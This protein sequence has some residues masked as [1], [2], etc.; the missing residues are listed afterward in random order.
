MSYFAYK[1]VYSTKIHYSFP[2]FTERLWLSCSTNRHDLE[3]KEG[4][5]TKPSIKHTGILCFDT[6]ENA[7]NFKSSLPK[8]TTR[9]FDAMVLNKLALPAMRFVNPDI[10]SEE[11]LEKLWKEKRLLQSIRIE[12]YA[13]WP[14]GTEAYESIMLL[15]ECKVSIWNNCEKYRESSYVQRL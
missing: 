6:L 4:L 1:V 14:E 15:Y 13:P 5:Y 12:L 2:S 7:M 11:D 8:N 3:Y 10:F 9:I